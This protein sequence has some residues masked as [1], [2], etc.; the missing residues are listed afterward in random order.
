MTQ[1]KFTVLAV[2]LCKLSVCTDEADPQVIEALSNADQPTGLSH[3]WTL[4]PAANFAS[5]E[6]NPCVC[7][8]DPHRKHYLLHC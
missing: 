6:T 3:K 8:K 4:D 7:E 5:G 1:A 2:G